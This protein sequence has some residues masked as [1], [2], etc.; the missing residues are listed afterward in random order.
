MRSSRRSPTLTRRLALIVATETYQSDEF[1]PL[2]GTVQDAEDLRRVLGDPHIGGFQVTVLQDATVRAAG[3]AIRRFF[4]RADPDDMLLLHVSGHGK[5]DDN[6]N[7]YFVNRDT[8]HDSL[9]ATGLA[10]VDIN[11]ELRHSAAR[12]IVVLLDC[13]YA[14]AF[15]PHDGVREAFPAPRPAAPP[16]A[17]YPR[18][19]EEDRHSRGEVVIT[20]ATSIEQAFETEADGS[21]IGSGLFTRCVVHGLESGH[22]DLDRDGEVDAH[23]LYQYVAGRMRRIAPGRRQTPTYSAHRVQGVLRIA[24]SPYVPVPGVP[25][26][27]PPPDPPPPEPVP[28]EPAPVSRPRGPLPR[29]ILVPLLVAAGL[30][31]GCVPQADST[32]AGG[33]CPTPAQV[34]VAAAPAGLS[35]YRDLAAGFERW[36]AA[37]Q[38]GCRTVDLYVYPVAADDLSE[39]LRRGWGQGEDGTNYLRDLGP[40][41][42]VWLPG[43]ATEVPD[44][45]TITDLVGQVQPVAHTPI[46][47]GV[48]ARARA[49]D[50]W[51]RSVLSW[52]DLVATVGR[53]S[54]VVRGDFTASAIA[55]MATAKLYADATI[56]TATARA[57]VEQ[58]I[59]RALDAGRY[60]IGDEADLLCRQRAAHGR[61]AIV[62]TEQQLVRFNRGDPLDGACPASTDGPGADD[63]LLAFYP[64]DTPKVRQVAVTLTWPRRV[65]TGTTRAYA[66]WFVRWLRQAPGRQALLRAGWRPIG[67]DAAEPVGPAYGA[68]TGWPFGHA[69][70]DEPGAVTRR[71]VAARYA[72]ARRPGRFLVA[73]DASG[74]MRTVTA[75]PDRTR[76]EVATAAVERAATRLGRRD[77]LGLLTFSTAGG[78]ASRTALPIASAGADPVAR[79]HRAVAALQPGG[80]TPLYQ[81][82]RDGSAALRGGGRAG[83]PASSAPGGLSDPLR[84]LVVLTDGQDTSGQPRPSPT[85]TAGVRIFV[86]AVGDV[87]C[88][89]AALAG[90][91]TG[92]GGRC[93]DAGLDSL[94][95]VLTGMFRAV[96]DT[97]ES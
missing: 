60:P 47:L 69:D 7:L 25:P 26:D 85:Q 74:S 3:L 90:L 45:D 8:M 24:H 5:R 51:R 20:A 79:V 77:E 15:V 58:P 78:R 96:W 40:H 44:D 21:Q 16:A 2:P 41:P 95:P 88:A 37:R 13:C 92:T 19:G 71:S 30:L 17:R 34:R 59:E 97:E 55:R 10:A 27:P 75:D 54:T 33:G 38:H 73:L 39:G 42:D 81:A 53:D 57:E 1:A 68:L 84:T 56:D 94:E 18:T 93:F 46:V 64:R 70:Q 67:Y 12:R 65:Q 76:F 61:A 82:I 32:V 72:A 63:R 62:L 9:W 14:G 29:R 35:A 22:A 87:S 66:A 28:P 49:D 52:R 83:P 91:A 23:E 80:G 86:I 4:S 6:G 50:S 43:T 31:G 11:R 48:P 89:D 36:V